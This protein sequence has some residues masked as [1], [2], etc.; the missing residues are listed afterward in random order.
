MVGYAFITPYFA[1]VIHRIVE[2]FGLEAPSKVSLKGLVF[3]C[4]EVLK[5]TGW[6]AN[7]E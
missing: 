5:N 4:F 2:Y 7:D 1:V 6:D 3:R